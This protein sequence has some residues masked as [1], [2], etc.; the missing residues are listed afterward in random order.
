LFQF[1][2]QGCS[3][4]IQSTRLPTRLSRK[5]NREPPEIEQLNQREHAWDSSLILSKNH[6][7]CRVSSVHESCTNV[8][9]IN[10]QHVTDATS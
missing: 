8:A 1:C 9:G 2:N 7:K 6:A 5:H 3:D 10:V 4:L